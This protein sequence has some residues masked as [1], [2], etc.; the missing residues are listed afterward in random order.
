MIYR[1][2]VQCFF[3]NK[4]VYKVLSI[5]ARDTKNISESSSNSMNNHWLKYKVK[6]YPPKYYQ[7][8]GIFTPRE[9]RNTEHLKFKYSP[10]TPEKAGG[11][12]IK[13]F[14]LKK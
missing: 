8:M 2:R 9:Q 4:T 3:F 5:S 12:K 7:G 11:G 14:L 6:E 1:L 10:S 13:L